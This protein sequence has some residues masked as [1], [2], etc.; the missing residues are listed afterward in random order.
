MKK[1]VYITLSFFAVL[2]IALV[3]IPWLFKD[4]ILQKVEQ[5]LD[6]SLNARVYFDYDQVSLSALRRFPNISARLGDFGVVGNA[7]FEADTLVDIGRLEVNFNLFSVLFGDYPELTGIRLEDGNVYVKVLSDGT[8]NYD[9]TY[10][11]EATEDG[12]PSQFKIGVNRIEVKNL[13]FIYDDREMDFFMALGALDLQGTGDFTLDVYDMVIKG[14]GQ[15]VRM[16]YEGSNYLLDKQLAV[17]TR[18]NVD[19]ENMLFSFGDA[20]ASLND[21]HFGV[22]GSIALPA[23]GIS[24]DLDFF[25]K[26]NTFKSLLSLV[27][28]MYTDSFSSLKTSG[29]MDFKG[30][31]R[32][33]YSDDRFPAFQLGLKV[34]DGMFQYPDLP[35]PVRD[36]SIDL[37]VDNPSGVVDQTEINLSDFSLKFGDQPISGRVY[38]QNLVDFD[39]DGRLVGSLDLAELTSIFPLEGMQLR[40]NLA[41]DA[42]AKGRYD[43]LTNTIPT[44]QAAMNFANGY[45]K[46]VEYPAAIEDIALRSTISNTTGKMNDLVVDVSS[47]GFKLDGEPVAGSLKIRDLEKLIWD[48]SVHGVVD[49]GKLLAIFPQENL[50]MEGRIQADIDSEGSYADV[51]AARYDRINVS[52]LVALNDFFFADADL[53]QG[54][55]IREAKADFSPRVIQLTKFDSRLGQSP[56][57]ATGRLSNYLAYLLGEEGAALVGNLDLQ[58]S[59][60]NVNEWLTTSGEPAGSDQPLQ[61]IDLPR[62]IDFNMSV[63]AGEII[64][65]NLVLKNARGNMALR[66]GILTF[67]NFSTN[68]LG[69][70]L[71][72]SGSY[73]SREIAAPLFDFVF[74]V[75]ALQIQDAFKTFNTIRIFA[76]VAEHITG[77]FTTRFELSGILGQD[78]MPVLSSLDGKGLVRLAETA[79]QNSQLI[80]G[81]TSLTRLNDSANLNL[82][83]FNI[84]AEIQDGMLKVPPFDLRIW[85]YEARIQG[86][87]G[88][89]G[90]IS[91]LVSMQ[92]PAEKFG[93]QLIGLASGLTGTDLSGT[94]IP[95]AINIGGT[96][97][98]PRIG[99]ATGDNLE[100]YL[101]NML[102]SRVS[103]A[104]TRVQEQLAAEFQAR[105]DSLR[106]EIRERAEVVKDSVR[107]EADRVLDQTKERAAEEVKGL[108][109][110]LTRPKP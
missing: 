20:S 42:T 30:F 8:A 55:R 17:D 73:N 44:I 93:S 50:I 46:S 64:Y 97:G 104:G 38:V 68:A 1:V 79:I 99:L 26:E 103:A 108:I 105:E 7:P 13:G 5:E 94:S 90:S 15:L 12:S 110:G 28:G 14:G 74:D 56:V 57:T 89:D 63:E 107:A 76:P 3:T 9:I 60:F 85:D 54:I 22:D 84:Q 25:G 100:G 58:S 109:R 65:D 51:E 67:R 70:S 31:V 18:V 16:D 10:P 75:N 86:S 91:Y 53:P 4:R 82:R 102:R 72:F 35:K 48:V 96:Y 34:E 61:V 98:N 11:S 27:P 62:N 41:I 2:L 71:G 95:L 106:Q 92:V 78:M 66:D 88:F 29:Q 39:L 49:L 101:T 80:R 32:G 69:G 40:G 36:V 52:G 45:V 23:D 24:F 59:S 19:L 81:I 87:T 43:S 37:L 21:F 77:S 83:P 6:A 33:I 47:V